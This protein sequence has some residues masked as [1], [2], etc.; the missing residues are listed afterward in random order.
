MAFMNEAS[1]EC[2]KSELDFFAMQPMQTSVEEAN[3]VK[4]PPVSSV[5]NRALLDF[6]IT[7]TGNHYIDMAN[8]MLMST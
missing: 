7:R 4:Y 5:Q 2:A 8:V 3:V 1:C 6:D